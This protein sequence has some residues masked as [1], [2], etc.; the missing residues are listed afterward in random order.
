MKRSILLL[1]GLLALG[2]SG[3][4]NAVP[5]GGDVCFPPNLD[6]PIY[7]GMEGEK[8]MLEL[9]ADLP[10]PTP[11]PQAVKDLL[12]VAD[13]FGFI[14]LH[15]LEFRS[16]S[17]RANLPGP[18][19]GPGSFV[20]PVARPTALA[21]QAKQLKR[22]MLLTLEE[23]EVQI[24]EAFGNGLLSPDDY[25]SLMTLRDTLESLISVAPIPLP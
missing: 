10:I 6:Q 17:F 12:R 19:P 1:V 15:S 16:I 13:G 14:A 23:L 21:A 4:A 3:Y 7:G 9:I 2:V 18:L 22:W 24:E 20:F 25:D 8:Y 11:Y 5:C